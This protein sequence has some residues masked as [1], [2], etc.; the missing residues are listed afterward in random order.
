MLFAEGLAVG[1][2]GDERLPGTR[3]SDLVTKR[4]FHGHAVFPELLEQMAAETVTLSAQN[5]FVIQDDSNRHARL[6]LAVCRT[7]Q[8]RRTTLLQ[9]ASTSFKANAHHACPEHGSRHTAFPLRGG[10]R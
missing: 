7:S 1:V 5:L 4:S 10:G 9:K 2:V 6:A 3:R 8:Q